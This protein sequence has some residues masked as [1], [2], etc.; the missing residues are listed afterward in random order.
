MRNKTIFLVLL[1]VFIFSVS[2]YSLPAMADQTEDEATIRKL[3]EQM[4]T[5]FNNH[6]AEGMAASWD[7]AIENWR[8]NR[9][10]AASVEYYS[11]LFKQQPRIKSNLLEEVGIV[12][13][14]PDVAIFKA[15]MDNT[16]LVDKEGKPR[17][18]VKWLGAWVFVK[19]D[20]KWL[21]TTFFSRPT[22]E[23]SVPIYAQEKEEEQKVELPKLFLEQKFD[24]AARF[25]YVQTC[26]GIA[27]AKSLGKSV[28]DFSEFAGK[29]YA[30]GWEGSKGQGVGALIQGTHR[31]ALAL[32][33]HI[34]IL[35]ESKQ[36]ITARLARSWIKYFGEDRLIYGV[37]VE[38]YEVWLKE[39]H[40][41]IAEYLGLEWKQKVDGDWIV[42]TVTE[43]SFTGK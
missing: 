26:I 31:N 29:L 28:E 20:G 43:K 21:N 41:A 18:Q 5:A 35:S 24:R 23:Y 13:L 32:N 11:D 39:A 6:D 2:I 42:I 14:T 37:S 17:P 4:N 19:K 1:F 34:E 8:G 22:E 25:F 3:V 36:S 38:E 9:K 15:L 7:E 16:G 10:G 33:S 40:L 30:P 12:F 27:Y